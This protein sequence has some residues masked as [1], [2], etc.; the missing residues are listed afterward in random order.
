MIIFKK[1]VFIILAPIFSENVGGM[2][3]KFSEEIEQ[4]LSDQ[5]SPVRRDFQ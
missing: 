4:Y 2:K 1:A 3:V 5:P